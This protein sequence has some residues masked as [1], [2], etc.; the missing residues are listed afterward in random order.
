MG[1]QEV[2]DEVIYLRSAGVDLGKRFLVACVRVPNPRRPGTW[3]LETE[4]FGTV[5]REIRRLLAWLLE[6]QVEVVILEAT[7]DY[8][9]YVYYT[10]QPELNVMLVNPQ[11][12]KGI[13]GR[14]TDPS[15]AA[16]LAR[17][18]ASGMVMGSFVS[19]EAIRQLRDLTRRRTEVTVARGQEL[20]RLEKEL[21][22][23][24][25]KLSSVITRLDGVSG[26]AILRALIGGQRD[27]R[28]LADLAVGVARKKTDQLVDALD[29]TFTEHHAWMCR[30]YLDQ[31]D[32]LDA[33]IGQLDARIAELTRD[34]DGDLIRLD[35]IPGIG[36][37]AAEII[38]VETGGDMAQF[39]TAGH[40]ASWIGVCPGVN[41]SA[42]VNKSGKTR[43]GNTNLK[44]ILGIAALSVTRVKDSYLAAFYRRTAARR[45]RQKALVAVMHKLAKAIW[46]V[47]HDHTIYQDLGGDYLTRRDP[48]RAMRR[49]TREANALGMTVRFD[50]IPQAA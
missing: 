21:E 8:W 42:G 46:H 44:R 2:K 9:R 48:A 41:E 34:H 47:L 33:L 38:L 13:R 37:R 7:S 22:D 31:I 40:L 11:H 5:P 17:A 16:F 12:L 23:T 43:D 50:P 18:G 6:R 39:A 15:D 28:A 49:M 26:R 45:G 35:T 36:L 27:Q 19:S 14:K 10:L 20:Q 24:G 29:G 4:K 1:R 32:H 3:S 25:M 30:H